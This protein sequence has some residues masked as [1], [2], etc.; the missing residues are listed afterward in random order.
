MMLHFGPDQVPQREPGPV[1]MLLQ[2]GDA[3]RRGALSQSTIWVDATD[4]YVEERLLQD[5]S[6]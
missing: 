3:G 2:R 6:A 4:A 5:I 1:R